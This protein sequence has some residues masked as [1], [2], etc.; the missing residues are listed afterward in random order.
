MACSGCGPMT[1]MEI[2]LSMLFCLGESFGSLLERLSQVDVHRVELLDE[3]LHRLNHQR[4][5]ALKEV[6]QSQDLEFTL[7]SPF[8]GINIAAPNPVLRKTVLKLLKESILHA[9]QLDCEMWVFHPGLRTGLSSFYLGEDWQL[10]LDSVRALLRFAR[11]HD[12]E[13]AIENVPEPYP[14]LMKGVG[15]FA[16]FYH[17]LGEDVGL[18][19]D[20]GHANLN[21]QIEDFIAHFADR[22]VHVHVSDNG[23]DSDSHLG[24]GYGNI[25]WERVAELLKETGY[26]NV[27][28]LESVEYVEDSLQTLRRL[29]T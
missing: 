11:R 20:I 10:N 17:E 16:R 6:A 15:D 2:G 14:F 12:V 27:I 18:T 26:S 28:M 5:R 23:G 4:I 24:V 13:I 7:H 29:F 22:I 9:H 1:N 21:N 3:G 8:A 25:D 19:L